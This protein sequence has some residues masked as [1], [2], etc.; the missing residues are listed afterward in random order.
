[1]KKAVFVG[2]CLISMELFGGMECGGSRFR[3]YS[4]DTSLLNSGNSRVRTFSEVP[5]K[6]QNKNLQEDKKALESQRNLIKGDIDFRKKLINKLQNAYP[7]NVKKSF[8]QDYGDFTF[9]GEILKD[10]AFVRAKITHKHGI[11]TIEGWFYENFLDLYRKVEITGANKNRTYVFEL[12]AW[13]NKSEYRRI[14]SIDDISR[15]ERTLYYD[16][17]LFLRFSRGSE[18]MAFN[19]EFVYKGELDNDELT[20]KGTMIMKTGEILSGRFYR[21]IYKGEE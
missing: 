14:I 4:E 9:H 11:V 17:S 7:L 19:H 3:T 5:Y 1:M 2:L 12:L 13:E 20:G 15:V 16:G 21:G 10:R 6:M 18:G 8:V